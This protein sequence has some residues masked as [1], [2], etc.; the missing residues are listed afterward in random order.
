MSCAKLVAAVNSTSITDRA[1]IFYIMVFWRIGAPNRKVLVPLTLFL[2][3]VRKQ[4][5]MQILFFFMYMGFY[6]LIFLH[7]KAPFMSI[8]L[9]YHLYIIGSMRTMQINTPYICMNPLACILD[10]YASF[11][12]FHSPGGRDYVWIKGTSAHGTASHFLHSTMLFFH[13]FQPLVM[14]RSLHR[15][16]AVHCTNCCCVVK[17]TSIDH[18]NCS[19]LTILG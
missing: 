2:G 10:W 8:S 18:S 9:F 4:S 15:S 14:V 12:I 13:W 11:T 16:L 5:S 6:F 19:Q 7:R 1:I 3:T 17:Y